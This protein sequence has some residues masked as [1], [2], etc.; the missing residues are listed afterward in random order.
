[1]YFTGGVGFLLNGYQK[2]HETFEPGYFQRYSDTT[3]ISSGDIDHVVSR[4]GFGLI[5]HIRLNKLWHITI[6]EG[7]TFMLTDLTIIK[8]ITEVRPG[9]LSLQVGLMRKLKPKTIDKGKTVEKEK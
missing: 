7:F 5:E 8:N 2:T 3:F 6:N 4:M 1:M 9:Y